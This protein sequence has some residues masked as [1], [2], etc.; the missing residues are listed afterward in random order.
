MSDKRNNPPAVYQYARILGVLP[1]EC[2]DAACG[3]GEVVDI[4][5]TVNALANRAARLVRK[6]PHRCWHR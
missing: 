3:D 2:G 1:C 4:T 5:T 6:H